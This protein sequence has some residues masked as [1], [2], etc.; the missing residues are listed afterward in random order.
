MTHLSLRSAIL[1]ALLSG[2]PALA[3]P[4]DFPTPEDA[5][6]AFIAALSARDVTAFNALFGDEALDMLMTGDP[7][8]DRA[9]RLVVLDLYAEG[10]R[11]QPGADGE[12]TL[13]LGADN[14]PF[15]IPLARGP[16]GWHFD[17]DAGRI[18]LAD[19]EIGRNEL[20]VIDL[21]DAYVD[22][23][24]EYR[25]TDYDGNGVMEFASHIL[26]SEPGV[27]DGLFWVGGEQSPMGERIAR[28]AL[29]G[30]S[31]GTT[32]Y[33]P[34]PYDG[35]YFRILHGQGASA[36]GGGLSY[37]VNGHLMAGHALLAVPAVYGETGVHTFMVAENG[38][39]FQAD[40]GEETLDLAEAMTLYD[41]GD[42]W[43]PVE[44]AEALVP[45]LSELEP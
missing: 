40:L 33:P 21:M 41:P 42:G 39:I 29:D 22:V 15:P 31:D 9:N 18:E 5:M 19:R 45:S 6:E 25:L 30:F 17:I 43:T 8:E 4:A 36:P 37:D 34:D 2:T 1:C 7:D 12:V 16:K 27:R 24:S 11:F 10:Y 3:G 38:V 35:Y 14:W 26:S 20:D 44:P 28:A 23:Q 13:V 32:D